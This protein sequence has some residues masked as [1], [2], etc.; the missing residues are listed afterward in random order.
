MLIAAQRRRESK[1]GGLGEEVR[2]E[3]SHGAKCHPRLSANLPADLAA[4][5]SSGRIPMHLGMQGVLPVVPNRTWFL[6]TSVLKL[7]KR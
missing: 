7:P 2:C 3:C 4:T 5:T 6:R 1:Q